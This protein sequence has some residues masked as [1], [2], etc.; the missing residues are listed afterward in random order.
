MVRAAKPDPEHGARLLDLWSPPPEAGEPVGCV[1]TTFTFDAGHFEEQ[2]LG[3]FLLMESD[4]AES[5]RTYLIEREE[6]LAQYEN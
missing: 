4:P 3:R 6:K 5:P 1:A 2:C